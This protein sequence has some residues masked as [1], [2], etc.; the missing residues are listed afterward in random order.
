MFCKMVIYGFEILH[1]INANSE[2][3]FESDLSNSEKRGG[4]EKIEVGKNLIHLLKDGG[5]LFRK[6]AT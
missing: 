3:L 6:K 2:I 5:C 1:I 4:K